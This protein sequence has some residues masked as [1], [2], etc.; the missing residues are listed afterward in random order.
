MN[1]PASAW[2]IQAKERSDSELILALN[3]YTSHQKDV[4]EVP[5]EE[6]IANFN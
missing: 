4:K 5:Q 3:T 6:R 1:K 2:K